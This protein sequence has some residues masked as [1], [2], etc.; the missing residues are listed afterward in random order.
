MRKL[1]VGIFS[2]LCLLGPMS[3]EAHSWQPTLGHTQIP[4]YPSGKV[5]AATQPL[6]GP[7]DM[8]KVNQPLVAG[9]SW[10]QVR[11]VSKPTMTIYSP[12]MKNT[13]VAM[14]VLPGGGYQILAID[15]EGTEI[16][17]WLTA[18]GITCVLLKYR[19]PAPRSAP[20]W[21]SYPQSPI[22]LEDLQRTMGLVRLNAAKWG[23]DPKKIGVI[24][25][26][27]GGSLVAEI[28]THF[29]HRL[30]QPIDSADKVS[31][32][33][34]FAIAIYPGHLWINHHKFEI[35]PTIQ[36]SKQTPPT[37]L[38][39]AENDHEDNVNDSLVYY[40]AL[41]NAGIPVE[42]HLYPNGGHAFGLRPTQ[43]PITRWPKLVMAWLNSIGMKLSK[44]K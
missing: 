6:T 7:E 25:F 43:F 1:F 26:S 22:A 36:V 17:H 19:V 3:I 40:I 33:P 9:K 15:L 29:K 35:N 32:R 4:I 11:N 39:Q 23:I 13:G 34:N 5:P 30:Y 37:F 42:M 2:M 21:G 20:Y 18:N 31:C 38:L 41:K 44:Y 10:I 16:C 24:G 14:V 28:S 12:K 8:I 27:A